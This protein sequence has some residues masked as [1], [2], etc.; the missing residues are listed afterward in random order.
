MDGTIIL[1]GAFTQPAAAIAQ[2]IPLRSDVDWMKVYNITEAAAANA[3]HGIEYYWQR[4]FSTDGALGVVNGGLVYRHNAAGDQLNLA[5]TV[6]DAFILYDNSANPN[7]VPRDTAASTAAANPV[8]TTAN[9]AGLVA[10]ETIVRL[11]SIAAAPTICGIDFTV[12]AIN[13]GVSLNL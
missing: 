13:A 11:D 6:A 3:N 8:V 12:Q 9:T 1:Q 4:G 10:F 5:T 7:G 2:Y